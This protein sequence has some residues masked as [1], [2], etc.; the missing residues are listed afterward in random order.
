MS[1]FE[2]DRMNQPGFAYPKGAGFRSR[3]EC[4][5]Y[6]HTSPATRMAVVSDDRVSTGETKY[7][8]CRN[9]R[10]EE[11]RGFIRWEPLYAK[12]ERAS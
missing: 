5:Y 7:P 2:Q 8:L 4:A 6:S 9:H 12:P 11:Q 1:I 3:Q 10:A